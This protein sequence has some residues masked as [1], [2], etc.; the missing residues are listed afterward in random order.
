MD[1]AGII[2]G[3]GIELHYS[4]YGLGGGT[5]PAGNRRAY[6]AEQAAHTPF[7]GMF[8]PYVKLEDPWSNSAA[9]RDYMHSFY[10]RTLQWLRQGGGPT[11]PIHACFLWNLGSWD[12]L[13][14]YP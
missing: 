1:V 3:R 11:Y 2:K 8:G 4:E 10:R 13:G 14:I 12:V 7:Y 9:V 5:S 6:S